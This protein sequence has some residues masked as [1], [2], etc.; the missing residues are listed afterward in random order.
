MQRRHTTPRSRKRQELLRELAADEVVYVVSG[1]GHSRAEEAVEALRRIES[2]TYGLCV[3]CGKRIP[4]ARLQVKPE[5]TRCIACQEEHEET[6]ASG[7]ADPNYLAR[8]TA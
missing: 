7:R 8:R 5:A 2:G 6:P 3:D 1:W 4:P